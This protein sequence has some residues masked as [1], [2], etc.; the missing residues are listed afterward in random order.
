MNDIARRISY[1]FLCIFP[2]LVGISAGMRDLRIPGVY[3]ALGVVLFLSIVIAA[4]FVGGRA[5]K[6]GAD[7]RRRFALAG[8][9]LIAP[10]A[11]ISLL[12]IGLAT[13]WDATA[14]E[15]EMRY[16]ILLF[17]SIAVTSGF[18][19][20]ERL[21]SEAGERFYSTLGFAANILAGAAYLVWTSFQMGA[22]A[23]QV[24]DGQMSPAIVALSN[25]FDILLFVACVL[26]YF[27]TAAFAASFGQTKWLKRGAVRA[28]IIMSFVA[29]L[30]I[31]L[32]GI[33]FPDP[34]AG[35][36][37]WYT[38]LGFIA[39]IPAVPWIMPFL[40]GVVLLRC[41]SDEQL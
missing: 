32:R 38:N 9:L 26:T 17:G 33:S 39:G 18:I 35:S 24:R 20:V 40:L 19:V 12:W 31:G 13:P 23:E 16:L 5:I 14:A 10:W 3:Q 36:T 34:T 21:L 1:V 30:F 4:W 29:L 27:S 6:S 28:Y 8:T 15:N 11:V 7:A 2:L 41:A 22:H 25:V 37:P